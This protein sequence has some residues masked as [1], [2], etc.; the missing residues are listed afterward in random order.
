M[1]SRFV[2]SVNEAGQFAPSQSWLGDTVSLSPKRL[3][4]K[5]NLSD[6]WPNYERPV[7]RTL[8]RMQGMGLL[9]MARMLFM[10]LPYGGMTTNAL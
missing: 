6:S 2:T 7:Y 10:R 8:R 1:N 9:A 4:V 3:N 5:G